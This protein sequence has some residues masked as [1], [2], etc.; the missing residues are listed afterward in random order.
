[1]EFRILGPLEVL[2]ASETVSLGGRREQALLAALVVEAD[3][4]VSADWLLD[5]LWGDDLPETG[6]KTLRSHQS[7]LRRR[8]RPWG[9]PIETVADGYVLRTDTAEIDAR[10]FERV[11]AAARTARGAITVPLQ[12]TLGGSS[13]RVRSSA[14]ATTLSKPLVRSPSTIAALSARAS[15]G[16]SPHADS[17]NSHATRTRRAVMAPRARRDAD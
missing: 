6:L 9:Q 2:A 17:P 5:A 12:R 14:I 13:H 8:L 16:S 15:S 7:R 10:E 4:I 3:R 11:L 1:M